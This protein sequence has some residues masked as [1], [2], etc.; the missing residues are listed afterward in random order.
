[1]FMSFHWF[2]FSTPHATIPVCT[3]VCSESV[4]NEQHRSQTENSR[5]GEKTWS[6]PELRFPAF[7]M[8]FRFIVSRWTRSLRVGLCGWR[9]KGCLRLFAAFESPD[10]AVVRVQPANEGGNILMEFEFIYW[11]A[12]L[13]P[14]FGL[15][16][17]AQR[18][19]NVCKFWLVAWRLAA[20]RTYYAPLKCQLNLLNKRWKVELRSKRRGKR[21]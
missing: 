17:A 1:M 4:L 8:Q 7:W 12:S 5:E 18:I 21:F 19:L 11:F 13:E 20:S 16:K 9:N 10:V 2:S 14:F 15:N 3:K 6:S